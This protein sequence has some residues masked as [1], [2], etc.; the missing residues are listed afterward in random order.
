MTEQA[1]ALFALVLRGLVDQDVQV[2]EVGLLGT[3]QVVPP[4]AHKV[5][6][7][8]HGPVGA[9]EG[10]GLTVGLAHVEGLNICNQIYGCVHYV[11]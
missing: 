4:V 3:V 7:V 6:L 2:V 5:L 11:E 10:C 8:E 9:Q 1:L